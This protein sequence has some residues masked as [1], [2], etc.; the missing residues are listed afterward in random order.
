MTCSVLSLIALG[1]IP[2][3][4]N[5]VSVYFLQTLLR[6]HKIKSPDGVH[7]EADPRMIYLNDSDLLESTKFQLKFN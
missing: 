6:F 7:R 2:N 1:A 3:F 4:S 5:D